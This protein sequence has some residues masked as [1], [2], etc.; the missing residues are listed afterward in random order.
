MK[1]RV[2]FSLDGNDWRP[3]YM[4]GTT[5]YFSSKKQAS[6]WFEKLIGSNNLDWRVGFLLRFRQGV[7]YRLVD[8]KGNQV[9]A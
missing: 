3:L 7:W 2:Q 4:V 9:K 8:R 5:V 6:E 1:Y